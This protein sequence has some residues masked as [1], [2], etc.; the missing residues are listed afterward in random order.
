ML[1]R[2][3][4]LFV[5]ALSGTVGEAIAQTPNAFPTRPV[6]FIV[7]FPPG[8]ATDILARLV[9][10]SLTATWGQQVYVENKPG[11]PGMIAGHNAAPDGYTM[12]IATSGM[13]VVNPSV[14]DKLPYDTLNDYTFIGG[15][16]ITP[17]VVVVSAAS[18]YKTLADLIEAAR[19]EPGKLNI[20][21]G[22]INNTQH[23]T[24]EY[25]KYVAGVNMVGI[26]YKGSANAVTDLLGGQISI[27]VDSLAATL[28][29]IKAGKF[30]ALAI[31]TLERVPQMPDLPTVAE[32]GYP[33][34]ESIGWQGLVV[35][36]GTPPDV[37][38]KISRDIARLLADPQ[39]QA[40]L[41]DKGMVPDPRG[42]G[43]WSQFVRAELAKWTEAAKRANIRATE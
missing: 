29:Q 42:A 38:D 10:D 28:P 2:L 19:R 22:G 14:Y 1:L 33:G 26:T 25:L 40:R 43:P 11:I 21:Y 39:M 41:I 8:Q 23:L 3:L 27:L 37:V 17:M 18:P 5:L 15:L 9:A 34:F 36:K 20:G 32:S 4:V 13:L 6:R 30:R 35:P 7:P 12:T 24:G 16:A 31:S